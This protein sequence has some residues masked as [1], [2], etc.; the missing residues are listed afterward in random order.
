MKRL[1]IFEECGDLPFPK[2]KFPLDWYLIINFATEN[3]NRQFRV[4]DVVDV[5]NALPHVDYPVDP[6]VGFD[7]W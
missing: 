3:K 5:E 2:F 7:E 6:K 1:W 4:L